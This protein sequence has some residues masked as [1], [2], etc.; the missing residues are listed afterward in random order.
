MNL[1]TIEKSMILCHP[2]TL[3]CNLPSEGFDEMII[4]LVY[5]NGPD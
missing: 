3:L 2:I 4:E 1:A 5:L